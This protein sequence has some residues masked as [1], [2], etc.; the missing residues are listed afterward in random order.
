MYNGC[1]LETIAWW[2]TCTGLETGSNTAVNKFW[3]IMRLSWQAV[4]TYNFNR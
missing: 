1:Y 2:C 3:L 4:F